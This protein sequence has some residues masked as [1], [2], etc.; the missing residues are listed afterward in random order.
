[1]TSKR[2]KKLPKKTSDI[3]CRKQL[4]KLLP[5]VKKNCTTKFDES[6]RFKFSNKQQTKE[7]VKLILRTIVNL[8]GGTGKENKSGSGVWRQ[9][10]HKKLKMQVQILQEVMNLLKKLKLVS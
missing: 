10:K 9:P 8:P 5:E 1:M 7:K 6:V 3:K 4:E 2:F